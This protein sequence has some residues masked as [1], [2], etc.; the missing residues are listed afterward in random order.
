MSREREPNAHVRAV[1]RSSASA[2]W[3]QEPYSGDLTIHS[4]RVELGGMH[5]DSIQEAGPSQ[6]TSPASNLHV[7]LIL[8]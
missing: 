1:S 2:V 5:H 6:S 4:T 3:L 8:G 7:R